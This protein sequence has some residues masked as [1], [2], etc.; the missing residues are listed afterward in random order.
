[1]KKRKINLLKHYIMLNFF[2]AMGL[3]A[4][5]LINFIATIIYVVILFEDMIDSL[6]IKLLVAILGFI[7]VFSSC[8]WWVYCIDIFNI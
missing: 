4:W 1:M 3:V 8:Y 2:I 5:F 6:T 7:L